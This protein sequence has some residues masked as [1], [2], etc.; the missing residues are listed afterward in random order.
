[1]QEKVTVLRGPL[2]GFLIA[3]NILF[4]GWLAVSIPYTIIDTSYGTL[5]LSD[6]ERLAYLRFW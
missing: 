2:L 6:W 1:M 3:I 4:F 5:H